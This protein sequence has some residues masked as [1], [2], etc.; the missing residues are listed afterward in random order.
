MTAA[1][2]SPPD[3]T[4]DGAVLGTVGYMSP[5]QVRGRA[6]DHR[7]DIFSFGCILYEAASR[8]RPF[9]ADSHVETMHKILHDNPQPV[10][11]VNPEAP[12]EVRRLIKRCLARNPDQ[13]LQSMKDLAIELQEIVDEYDTLSPSGSTS[14][15]A[16]SGIL[17]T[18]AKRGKPLLITI[19]AIVA[20]GLAGLIF[21]VASLLRGKGSDP[22][23][24]TAP[25]NLEW[26]IVLSDAALQESALSAD[27][28]YLAYVKNPAEGWGVWVRQVATGSEVE[29]V[30]PGPNRIR[31][32][33]FSPDSN[34]L[35]FTQRDPESPNY[36]ALFE[37]PSLGGL[38]R[39]RLFDVD[40]AVSFSPDGTEVC[41]MRG[42]P[43]NNVSTLVIAN[44]ATGSD[45]VV[46]QAPSGAFVDP[47]WSPSGKHIVSIQ[48]VSVS[49]SRLIVVDLPG[50]EM[51]QMGPDWIYIN[52]CAWLPADA[53]VA[54]AAVDLN[55]NRM[56]IFRVSHPEGK[57]QRITNDM[58][59]YI[60]VS[61]S[62]DGTVIAAGRQFRASN[63]WS[64]GVQGTP[65]Q[66]TRG[67]A[68]S[69]SVR[70]FASTANGSI[71]V[72]M[73][74]SSTRLLFV[75]DPGSSSPRQLTSGNVYDERPICVP[76]G[77]TILFTRF[78][79]DKLPHVW[80]VDLDGGNLVQL[81]RGSGETL[82][83]QVPASGAFPFLTM[84]MDS[85]LVGRLDG[86][87]PRLVRVS[88]SPLEAFWIS[89][90]GR[91]MCMAELREHNGRIRTH[92]IVR[93]M[94]GGEEIAAFVFPVNAGIRWS[95]DSNALTYT[96]GDGSGTQLLRQALDGGSPVSLLDLADG[97][98]LQHAWS[99]D[100]TLVALKVRQ[101]PLMNLR[102]ASMP[103]GESEPVTD[104]RSGEIFDFKWTPDGKSIL[105]TQG[106]RE[107]DVVLL[108]NFQ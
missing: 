41:F 6:V 46:A 103:G 78:G 48:T 74:Q 38:P 30:A 29:L 7:S 19:G 31:G 40:T 104:F 3:I 107:G 98:L 22:V 10:E 2:T 32:I 60:E 21:G 8:R 96:I 95:P 45:R 89:P 26:T 15:A 35:Y 65:R 87:E 83:D 27:G 72:A 37:I 49:E 12:R 101:G 92:W 4:D 9:S 93:S 102:I 105:F 14:T 80:R 52:S 69:G 13:R 53:G 90:D 51:R 61:A 24:A 75:M 28:R 11:E 77:N 39:K 57:T 106:T 17:E 47:Q 81:T 97:A 23:A 68:R 85:V 5:E 79:E 100:G 43:Q 58:D 99:P 36:S 94:E 50:G 33:S 34:Y 73:D 16:G 86:G 108:R 42:L 56:Q 62:D 1:A 76:G 84:T 18:G 64:T 59:E 25:A 67:S 88:E 71:V 44:L 70:Q 20:L 63:L 82:L 55:S 66:L 54:V 91:L